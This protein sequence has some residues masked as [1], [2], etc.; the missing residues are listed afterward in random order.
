M[1]ELPRSQ[2][3]N[4]PEKK[5]RAV[6][7]ADKGR[8]ERRA[9][10][11]AE[12]TEAV[13]KK[14]AGFFKRLWKHNL[15]ERITHQS[16]LAEARNSIEETGSVY[17]DVQVS[18]TAIAETTAET[19]RRFST[20]LS[21]L[22]DDTA[23]REQA[24]ETLIHK[25]L[26]EYRKQAPE[27]IKA[28]VVDLVKEHIQHPMTEAALK[29]RAMAISAAAFPGNAERA[30][31]IAETAV[32]VAEAFHDNVS[33][34]GGIDNLN[35][36]LEV[37][38]GEAVAGPRTE[39]FETW[40]NK[41]IT[42]VS[43]SKLGAWAGQDI[44]QSL[45]LKKLIH[46]SMNAYDITDK[47]YVAAG[48][49]AVSGV[50]AKGVSVLQGRTV[51]GA[52]I[53]GAGV[54]GGGV[55]VGLL[56]SSGIM[57][58]TVGAMRARN[59]Y[60]QELSRNI[61][62]RAQRKS[63]AAPHE[64]ESKSFEVME[65]P[66]ATELAKSIQTALA[67][68]E[69]NCTPEEKQVRMDRLVNELSAVNAR[70]YMSDHNLHLQKR[71]LIAGEQRVVYGEEKTWRSRQMDFIAGS[72]IPTFSQEMD[73]LDMLRAETVVAIRR[74][75]QQNPELARHIPEGAQGLARLLANKRE[76]AITDLI[77]RD[78]GVAD[79]LE[80]I[81]SDKWASVKK[82]AKWGAVIGT[83]IG[84]VAQELAAY[85]SETR[86][87]ILE[88]IQAKWN[89]KNL[90]VQG[91]ML[92]PLESLMH[93]REWWQGHAAP[94]ANIPTLGGQSRIAF[95]EG[96]EVRPSNN[97]DTR[98][99][100]YFENGKRKAGFKITS[101]GKLDAQSV[102]ALRARG[103]TVKE[104]PYTLTGKLPGKTV[105][106]S[107]LLHEIMEDKGHPLHGSV[108]YIDKKICVEDP[109]YGN[110]KHFAWTEEN[111]EYVAR[112][113]APEKMTHGGVNMAELATAD[114]EQ[115]DL[116]ILF[117]IGD[118]TEGKVLEVPVINSGGQLE[119]RIPP[120]H[121][122][123]GLFADKGGKV[124]FLGK[125]TELGFMR[126]HSDK[127]DTYGYDIF[128]RETGGKGVDKL[129]L[130]S[131]AQPE[132]MYE[133]VFEPDA[134][135]Q[136]TSI[137]LPPVIPIV[138]EVK[139]KLTKTPEA[140]SPSPSPIPNTFQTPVAPNASR[141]ARMTPDR[142][143]RPISP[144]NKPARNN[145]DAHD[146][147]TAEMP[148]VTKKYAEIITNPD[149]LPQ[150]YAQMHRLDSPAE[151][152]PGDLSYIQTHLDI[153]QD[154]LDKNALTKQ[155][156]SELV[157]RAL[158]VESVLAE[159]GINK[160]T[161]EVSTSDRRQ[162]LQLTATR[163]DQWYT[164]VEDK[165]PEDEKV[166]IEN[167]IARLLDLTQLRLLG[168]EELTLR[169]NQLEEANNLA[170]S[171]R[172]VLGKYPRPV[173]PTTTTNQAKT[174]ADPTATDLETPRKNIEMLWFVITQNRIPLTF[175]NRGNFT[176]SEEQIA[177]NLSTIEANLNV[178]RQNNEM[179]LEIFDGVEI[180]NMPTAR[181]LRRTGGLILRIPLSTR[182][183][184]AELTEIFNQLP[185]KRELIAQ[186]EQK[187]ETQ[188][189]IAA[190]Y[191][192]PYYIGNAKL[193]YNKLKKSHTKEALQSIP[194]L[195]AS[196]EDYE[197]RKSLLTDSDIPAIIATGN[198]LEEEFARRGIYYKNAPEQ[199]KP[200]K[201]DRELEA[202]GKLVYNE[203]QALW[204]KAVGSQFR[205]GK[206]AYY[207]LDKSKE[208]NK[209]KLFAEHEADVR[210][211]VALLIKYKDY[212]T[213]NFS[214]V[215]IG[216]NVDA[217]EINKS[218]AGK[219][220][221]KFLFMPFTACN[222]DTL[223]DVI[224]TE[225]RSIIEVRK[226]ELETTD[227]EAK[228]RQI[229]ELKELN[230]QFDA[231]ARAISD[232]DFLEL[233]IMLADL[234]T[235]INSNSTE[236]AYREQIDRQLAIA[237]NR[238]EQANK[239]QPE[240]NAK[241][242]TSEATLEAS[243][244]TNTETGI[245]KRERSDAEGFVS[246]TF[247]WSAQMRFQGLQKTHS[248]IELRG[249]LPLIG[250]LRQFINHDAP[251]TPVQIEEI[252]RT[253]DE[254]FAKFNEL[255]NT[256]SP[257]PVA[258]EAI[259]I[260]KP[261]LRIKLVNTTATPPQANIEEGATNAAANET[262]PT[263][264]AEWQ[265]IQSEII[266][267]WNKQDL[268]HHELAFHLHTNQIEE[269][270]ANI[271]QNLELV[272]LFSEE[273]DAVAPNMPVIV[274]DRDVVYM[275]EGTPPTLYVPATRKTNINEIQMALG[276]NVPTKRTPPSK[277]EPKDTP[278]LPTPPPNFSANNE[279]GKE[280]AE[281][282]ELKAK[283]LG[284]VYIIN[285]TGRLDA[286]KRQIGETAGAVQATE[287]IAFLLMHNQVPGLPL[288]PAE[289]TLRA[290]RAEQFLREA[291]TSIKLRQAEVIRDLGKAK[292]TEPAPSNVARQEQTP[293]P[294]NIGLEEAFA[295]QERLREVST[296]I[297]PENELLEN[298]R[299]L[300]ANINKAALKV[301]KSEAEQLKLNR[302]AARLEELLTQLEQLPH[303]ETEKVDEAEVNTPA[304]PPAPPTAPPL[305]KDAY[306]EMKRIAK[307]HGTYSE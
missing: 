120:T 160:D 171:I 241:T 302:Q 99:Y 130:P 218:L 33:H 36:V 229:A 148:E 267:E 35:N 221:R 4:T 106:A 113:N 27:D 203:V 230:D 300:L 74:E 79:T 191:I 172:N 177:E 119:V 125:S 45:V 273:L 71:F 117:S 145:P 165:L 91:K 19:L 226:A 59:N 55:G 161:V 101:Q 298:A 195:I 184:S 86:V 87:G 3:V 196:L 233:N 1:R 100:E 261:K 285:Q 257:A 67:E 82:A 293:S 259:K 58:A 13:E 197:R 198:K 307:E 243:T 214:A 66:Q 190:S 271:R 141:P 295:L 89:G 16:K 179:L 15:I 23:L 209:F 129:T 22:D 159:Y 189:R 277:P 270:Q 216:T 95:P 244:N 252:N 240:N 49:A 38:I 40:T 188:R 264:Q 122:A 10:E 144:P 305:D 220:W 111:G 43:N 11:I 231:A 297:D 98:V 9:L 278:P 258:T 192:E 151:T 162:F 60:E 249:L 6:I 81:K 250:R 170:V 2:D 107:D 20:D 153:I 202:R 255:E 14:H 201:S 219:R 92:T 39:Q 72:S 93:L 292:Q 260:E 147:P 44:E 174:E 303:A 227:K 140:V 102:T 103:I 137:E 237:R 88:E 200:E 132:E 96:A 193:D 225:D 204:N 290:E 299:L 84:A 213:K 228:P 268:Q 90:N 276:I 135:M 194:P 42:K 116:K 109:L 5:F 157:H 17:P 253:G 62:L 272:A 105:N 187:A 24:E 138:P 301:K 85:F 94:H 83:G 251:L 115:S 262:T 158:E 178:L 275:R 124:S 50:A 246:P 306:A 238:L 232:K 236:R 25:S 150:L 205:M 104:V 64:A 186:T 73:Q 152:K 175:E 288:N 68:F 176:I 248:E 70:V 118:S 34:H 114:A 206:L 212:I 291:E 61:R 284:S 108:K 31:N 163:F 294:T 283:Y 26:G 131:T 123:F 222:E 286:V 289:I 167:N 242:A 281:L 269:F 256:A 143:A 8:K 154:L 30:N 47:E 57:G 239:T 166:L 28:F 65:L 173:K 263:E 54:V 296:Q 211:N 78:G 134:R 136:D 181:P 12:N 254:L 199:R 185:S 224:A 180:Q 97:G 37:Y 169:A 76:L 304:Q 80:K 168:N 29:Q 21:E 247:I 133:L 48:L 164:D 139:S 56:A 280:T 32:A 215:T 63:D 126:L 7:V 18:D 149:Y 146:A 274:N 265:K 208:E 128:A 279:A 223:V 110:G 121:P 41:L 53:V 245:E 77:Q 142:P 182:I 210:G 75:L 52:M 155:E 282:D 207:D 156:R 51:S 46:W 234:Q 112:L 217:P 287:D 69:E 266:A 235:L 127:S 183:T